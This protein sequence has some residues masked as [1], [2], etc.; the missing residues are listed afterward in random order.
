M[1]YVKAD[2]AIYSHAVDVCVQCMSEP[3]ILG[4]NLDFSSCDNMVGFLNPVTFVY[5]YGLP[6]IPN[7]FS[8]SLP[9]M[10][11]STCEST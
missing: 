1:P 8:Q 5:H 9:G 3:L 7:T 10:G 4:H 2:L 6:Y 11:R